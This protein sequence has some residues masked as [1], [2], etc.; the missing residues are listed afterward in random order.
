MVNGDLALTTLDF[1]AYMER[2]PADRRDEFRA[3]LSRIN[4]T[5]DALWIRR[6]MAARARAEGL[7]Q[8]PIVA[9]RLRLAQEEV[10][11]ETYIAEVGKRTKVPNLEVRARELYKAN[12]KQFAVPELVTVQHILVSTKTYPRDVAQ[13]RAQEIY[14]RVTGAGEDFAAVAERFTD[15]HA[16]TEIKAMQLSAFEKPLPEALAKLQPGQVSAPIETQFGFHIVKMNE[17]R[18]PRV[19][20][21]DEVKDDLIAMEKQKV[22][23]DEKTAIVDAIRGAP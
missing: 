14:Q 13:A 12:L 10:L 7:D 5:I 4:P 16:S 19:K 23:D 9:A 21:F 18:A 17:K 6:V 2:V 15:N 20:T 1:D 8:D 3:Q 11:A 22:V